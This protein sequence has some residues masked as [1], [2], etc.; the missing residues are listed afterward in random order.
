[1]SGDVRKIRER[2]FDTYGCARSDLVALCG[3]ADRLAISAEDDP[4]WIEDYGAGS[5]VGV[6]DRLLWTSPAS[7]DSSALESKA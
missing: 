4:A 2:D 5:A 1:L 7:P 6:V 3:L